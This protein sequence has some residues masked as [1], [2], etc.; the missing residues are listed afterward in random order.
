MYLQCRFCLEVNEKLEPLFGTENSPLTNQIATLNSLYLE[1]KDFDGWPSRICLDCKSKLTVTHN[2]IIGYLKSHK[3]LKE[4]FGANLNNTFDED[5]D[6][7]QKS[8]Q[9]SE[10][11]D[12]DSSVHSEEW[13]SDSDFNGFTP[14]DSGDSR[15]LFGS[16][17]EQTGKY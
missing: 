5:D 7:S 8:S 2:F 13:S 16:Q 17:S 9:S 1:I 3:I 11:E 14:S 15:S 4:Q 12:E 10:L 6:S